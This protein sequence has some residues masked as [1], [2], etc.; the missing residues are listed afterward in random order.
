MPCSW[1][2]APERMC[3]SLLESRDAWL[4]TVPWRRGWL[5]LGVGGEVSVGTCV[6]LGAAQ[7]F[8][9]FHPVSSCPLLSRNG[10]N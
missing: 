7:P 5:R 3:P 4:Q 8:F 6:Q 10:H 1:I 2:G 9:L